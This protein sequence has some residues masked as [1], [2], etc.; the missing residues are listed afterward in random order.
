MNTTCFP[1]NKKMCAECSPIIRRLIAECWA[2]IWLI[3]GEHSAIVLRNH[4][5]NTILAINRRLYAKNL[6]IICRKLAVCSTNDRQMFAERSAIKITP[7]LSPN[8]CQPFAKQSPN[9]WQIYMSRKGIGCNVQFLLPTDFIKFAYFH[10]PTTPTFSRQL[11]CKHPNFATK[12]DHKL[13]ARCSQAQC[14]WGLRSKLHLYRYLC[15]WCQS[16]AIK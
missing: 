16:K 2:I 12:S 4:T 6:Q 8:I 13:V 1:P 3:V 11:I 14:D 10:S 9:Y 15:N 7:K 5:F